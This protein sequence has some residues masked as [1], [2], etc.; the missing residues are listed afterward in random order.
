MPDIETTED[1]RILALSKHLST[2]LSAK[3][4]HLKP[5]QNKS[6][7]TLAPPKSLPTYKHK[8]SHIAREYM[9]VHAVISSAQLPPIAD[10]RTSWVASSGILDLSLP[11][12][13][14]TIWEIH[15]GV[16][17]GKKTK[18]PVKRKAATQTNSI[19]SSNAGG[20]D[21]GSRDLGSRRGRR[22]AHRDP[23]QEAADPGIGFGRIMFY[24]NV[25]TSLSI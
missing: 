18:T 24:I 16:K 25:S 2:L 12:A 10:M 22:G 11:T 20:H 15:T 4:F 21:T 3:G 1:Q 13:S 19:S 6:K 8:F 7:L 23:A 17:A 9:P 5:A 14:K